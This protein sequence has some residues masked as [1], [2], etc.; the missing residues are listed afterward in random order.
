MQKSVE[1]PANAKDNPVDWLISLRPEYLKTPLALWEGRYS[2]IF[3]LEFAQ[4]RAAFPE[5]LG[6]ATDYLFAASGYMS[7]D[8]L[9][10]ILFQDIESRSIDRQA[11][12]QGGFPW[13]DETH[14]WPMIETPDGQSIPARPTLQLNMV[15]IGK[16]M[17]VDLPPVLYQLWADEVGERIIALEG[18]SGTVPSW[19]FPDPEAFPDAVFESHGWKCELDRGQ[20]NLNHIG[21]QIGVSERRTFLLA[22]LEWCLAGR[23]PDYGMSSKPWED[24]L[25]W[26]CVRLGYGTEVEGLL[27]RLDRSDESR[28]QEF[29]TR[30]TS[31]AAINSSEINNQW[32]GAEDSGRFFGYPVRMLGSTKYQD[33]VL[34]GRR[35]LYEPAPRIDWDSSGLDF[36]AGD[37]SLF[38][39]HRVL[40]GPLD[41]DPDSANDEF[42]YESGYRDS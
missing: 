34:T 33:L 16:A 20:E 3:L 42:S 14:P 26:F 9:Q 18:I 25:Q 30:A 17:S 2:S 39:L 24:L 28:R 6:V 35:M 29:L 12:M 37:G 27:E 10:P 21:N 8:I 38:V 23:A 41:F 15:E 13:T 4:L 22:D 36:Y 7:D 40:K 31:L 19:D 11:S 5:Y 1:M 32:D